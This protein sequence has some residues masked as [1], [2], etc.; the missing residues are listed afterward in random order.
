MQLVIVESPTKAR[1]I[2]KF[3]PKGFKVESSFGHVR[4][5]PQKELGVDTEH[6]F[7][8][9]YVVPD[10]SKKQVAKLQELASRA[11]EVILASDED[12]EGEAISWHLLKLL[13]PKHYQRI[14]FHEITKGAIEEAL[15]KPRNVDM[16]LVDAQ[17]A[18]RVLDRLVGYELSPFLWKKVARGL[19]AGRVQSVAVRLVVE[20]ERE[21][22]KFKT[23]E[24]WTI[25]AKFAKDSNEFE[26]KLNAVDGKTLK[27]IAIKNQEAADK[28]LAELKSQGFKVVAVTAKESKKNPPVPFTTSTLQQASNNKLHFT[29]KQTMMFAQQ[30][31]EGV[32]LETESVGLITYMRTDS[33]NLAESFVSVARNYIKEKVGADYLPATANKFKT[34]SKGAQEAHEAIRPTHVERTPESVKRFL[35]EDQ[36][37][38]YEL[39]WERTLATQMKPAILS[40][41]AVDINTNDDKYSF[42][43]NGQTIKF[44]G[45][46][47]IYP[48]QTKENVLPLLAE[49]DAVEN[50]EILPAQHFT[51]PPARY[52][53]AS[54]IKVLEEYGIGRPS[55]YAP[56]LATIHDRGYVEKENKA[57][58]PT[59]IG[60]LVNDILVEHFPH[61]VDYDFTADMEKKLD[62]I[63]EGKIEW[64][65]VIAEF[66]KP[67][68]ENL[69]AKTKS[70]SKDS[71][72]SEKT[73]EICEKCGEPMVIRTGRFGRFF[74][75]SGYPTCKN[76]RK[77]VKV[78]THI[79]GDPIPTVLPEEAKLLDE[80]C[81]DC[82]NPLIERMGRFG[83]FTGCSTYPK[84]KYIVKKN[85]GTGVHC[86][87]CEKGEIVSKM[88][89]TKKMFFACN[90]Y[91]DCK[92]VMWDRPTG[93]KCPICQSLMMKNMQE[94]IKCS[95]KDC[96][97][98]PAKK[99]KEKKEPAE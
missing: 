81:P 68:K 10:K 72:S 1:T 54:L 7:E 35:T 36:F 60:C 65:P 46:L 6:N 67:F 40:A 16:N 64:Q 42:R 82:G 97:S 11:D 20:R 17:Q 34:K 4:D 66:Y 8:P 51:E 9:K 77:I 58:K 85:Y 47:K 18:R 27:K 30:L 73:D 87:Q 56:T 41:T 98:H 21:R 76:T 3:L 80:K 19:S 49:G 14:T 62:A 2:S 69:V 59:E 70:L 83:K 91:P 79:P 61:I 99:T 78:A 88:A 38:L 37:K 25:D 92:F 86:P 63:G 24:Y 39:I 93:E 57:L 45:Y 5:L 29:A 84:C 96:S 43:A 15:K 95:N 26:A 55:T 71:L 50:K 52:T 53:E 13:N 23:E 31:Y 74:A 44:D 12:R 89:R 48:E 33:L 32:K 90:Q 22:E 28:I 75:C 94:Q